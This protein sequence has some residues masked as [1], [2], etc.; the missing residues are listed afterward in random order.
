M[1]GILLLCR[2]IMQTSKAS[3]VSILWSFFKKKK[4]QQELSLSNTASPIKTVLLFMQR[5]THH[6]KCYSAFSLYAIKF[7]FVFFSFASTYL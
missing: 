1:E 5:V 7:Y 2:S 6:S 3:V 4:K